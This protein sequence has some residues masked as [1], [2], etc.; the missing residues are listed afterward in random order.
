MFEITTEIVKNAKT[1][2]PIGDK[3]MLA[4][5]IAANCVTQIGYTLNVGDIPI[6]V[7]DWCGRNAPMK[8]RYLLG[9]LL[10]YYLGFEI[11]PVENTSCLL[12]MDDFDRAAEHHPKNTLERCKG[13]KDTRDIAFDLLADYKALCDMVK[14]ALD[15]T[16]SARNDPVARFLASQAMATTPEALQALSDAEDALQKNLDALKEIA[17]K[18]GAALQKKGK[19]ITKKAKQIPEV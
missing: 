3:I 14:V 7:P 5:E 2:L 13:D 6:D 10:K 1:Y 18:A 11:E 12:S 17:P 19:E 9:A 16:I 15:D 8:D 4:G